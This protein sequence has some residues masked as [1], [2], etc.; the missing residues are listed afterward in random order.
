M[1]AD[2]ITQVVTSLLAEDLIQVDP[3]LRAPF[4]ACRREFV[5][6]VDDYSY[7][8][9]IPLPDGMADSTNCYIS[10]EWYRNLDLNDP[11]FSYDDVAEIVYQT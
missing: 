10:K 9:C 4:S 11:N 6:V 2:N 5:E 1:P 3:T 8:K 7:C